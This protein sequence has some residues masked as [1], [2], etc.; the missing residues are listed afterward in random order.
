LAARPDVVERDLGPGTIVPGFVDAH[1]H[2]TLRP[3]EGD[4][5]G[6]AEAAA[7]WQTIRGIENLRRMLS[8]GVTTARIMTE[9]H[10][11]DYEFRDAIARGEVPGPRLLVSGA[12][13]SPPGGHGCTGPG[14]AG[15]TA[16]RAAV[17]DRIEH[18][19]DHI[20]IF[21]T[22][23]V[24]SSTGALSDSQYSGAEIVAVVDEAA[25]AGL[26][27]S[28][29]AH[30]GEGVTLAVANGIHSI[31][32]GVLLSQ[33]NIDEMLARDVWLVLTT[34]ILHHPD[35]IERG[36]G[37]DPAIMTKV[38]E[39]RTASAATA[40]RV[41]RNGIRIAV[42]TDSMH[43]LFG[44]EVAWLVDHGWS[45]LEALIAATSAGAELIGRDDIGVLR[46]GSRADFVLLER[47]PFDDITAV[48]DIAAVYQDGCR[49]A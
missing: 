43:G 26:R 9:E 15:V 30:G 1:T 34:T 25:R 16:L 38:R 48:H 19:A 44:H 10:H 6:Q 21:T 32:H 45:P 47:D 49:V 41:R 7:V 40:E 46:A 4:Q 14:V 3:G 33:H 28:A 8:S 13:L 11:I 31:E 35:G 17:R 29:H 18:G 22:G 39:A 2:V 23:G 12:G 20:K 24:S 5:D 42:G 27:V 37:S 36:D